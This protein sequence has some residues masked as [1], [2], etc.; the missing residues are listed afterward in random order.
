MP[1]KVLVREQE[2]VAEK[3][4]I[5][6][7][8]T[9]RL[10]V[11]LAWFGV[12]LGVAALVDYAVALLPTHFSSGEWEFGTVSQVIAGLPLLSL[13]L[14]L[15]WLSGAGSGRRWVLLTVGVALELAALVVLVL[16]LAF[17]LD[18]PLAMKT[19]AGEARSQVIKMIVKT[20]FLGV[21]FGA[22]YILT[23]VLA[24]RQARGTPSQETGA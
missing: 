15:I 11:A 1:S 3:K 20:L 18:I 12:V 4:A 24:F 6:P 10:T 13:A 2:G 23:G 7:W 21:M 14:G 22:A 19:T 17:A 8:P 9:S 16:L 5:A